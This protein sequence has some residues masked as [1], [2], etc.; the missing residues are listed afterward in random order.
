MQLWMVKPAG[1]TG[2]GESDS[3]L[4]ALVYLDQDAGGD[5]VEHQ[6][7]GIDQE[8]VLGPGNARAD[9]GEDQIAPAVQSDQAVARSQVDAELPFG[10]A[11]FVFEGW[12][13]HASIACWFG[14]E[15]SHVLPLGTMVQAPRAQFGF[16]VRTAI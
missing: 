13:V 8:V 16:L 11:D 6:P 3:L 10:G 5:L 7:I 4:P 1:F 15:M 14:H 2:K 12:D 9:V